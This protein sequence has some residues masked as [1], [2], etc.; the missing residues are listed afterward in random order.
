M[1]LIR[2]IGPIGPIGPIR[3]WW[4]G[5]ELRP[6]TTVQ[7]PTANCQPRTPNSIHDMESGGAK[8]LDRLLQLLV[9]HQDVIGIKCADW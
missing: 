6:A 1:R 9:A 4:S 3:I 2:L 7:P 8:R 5:I